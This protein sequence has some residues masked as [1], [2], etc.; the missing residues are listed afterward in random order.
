MI[1]D[2]QARQLC[3]SSQST[4]LQSGP[5]PG[6]IR[7]INRR[8]AEIGE[9][10][11]PGDVV[12]HNHAYYGASH[13]PDVGFVV[14]IF[15]GGKLVG[16]SAHDRAPPRPRRADA[17]LVRHRRR[18]RRVRRGPAVQRDQDR[19]GGPPQRVVWRFIRDNVRAAQL[20]VGDMEAQVAACR[21]GAERFVELIER[22][23]LETVEGASEDLMDYSERTAAARDREAPGRHLRGRGLHRRLPRRPRPGEPRPADQGDGDRRGLRHPRRPH[24]HLAADRPAAEHAVRGHGRHRDLPDAPLDPARYATPRQ[25]AGELRPLPADHDHGARGL[26]RE[27]ALSRRRRSRASAPATSSPTRS[28]ARWRR[29]CRTTSAPV[30]AT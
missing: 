19:G 3:E 15:H 21:I 1:C 6:Y 17:G 23:G 20:V 22:Y 14:P 2:G 4:P 7:G 30:S 27:P 11:K 5:I 18:D 12:I 25:C 26:S 16:F 28:C 13:E 9:E 8:F 10:W 24:R 29:S